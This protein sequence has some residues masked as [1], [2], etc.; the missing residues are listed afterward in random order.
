M[1]GARGSFR[2]STRSR[3][4][5][6]VVVTALVASSL[7]G[8]GAAGAVTGASAGASTAAPTAAPAATSI[9]IRTVQ[10]SVAPG[11][12]GAVVGNLQVE[13]LP[14]EGRE[15]A[16]EARARGEATFTPV[17]TALAGSRGNVRLVVRPEVTTRYRWAYAGD[18]D[19]QPRLSGVAT[20]R[21]R[22][23]ERPQR[24]HATTLSARAVK[25]VVGAGRRAVLR[26]TLRA[27][28]TV[29]PGKSVVLLSRTATEPEWQFVTSKR[30]GREGRIRFGVRPRVQTTYQLGY[31]GSAT[32]RPTTS[33]IVD[34]DVRPTVTIIAEPPQVQPGESTLVAGSVVHGESPVAGAT[35]ELRERTQPSTRWQVADTSVSAAD[36]TVSFTVTPEG[37]TRYRLRVVPAAGLPS[38]RSRAVEVQVRAPDTGYRRSYAGVRVVAPG[39]AAR[40]G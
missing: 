35:V 24:R 40:T 19:A 32:F 17:G 27:S 30:T 29:L 13:G 36:G 14:A 1:T 34:V 16:L 8:S 3:V 20:L 2:A 9:S 18:T 38:G 10:P 33:A 12:T 21:V 22:T 31:A 4:R 15:L 28:H 23:S 7:V 26:G 37:T 6:G 39:G 5:R 25:G 11:R